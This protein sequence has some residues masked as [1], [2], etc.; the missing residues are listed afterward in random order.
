MAGDVLSAGAGLA[1]PGGA[2]QLLGAGPHSYLQP[3]DITARIQVSWAGTN[4]GLQ[5]RRDRRALP[6]LGAA[7]VVIVQITNGSCK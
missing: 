2:C 7:A 6:S 1:R 4:A 3:G 5:V